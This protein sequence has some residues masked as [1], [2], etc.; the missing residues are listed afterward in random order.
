MGLPLQ[1]FFFRSTDTYLAVK[2]CGFDPSIK[3][4]ETSDLKQIRC[5]YAY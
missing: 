1:V 4:Q 2:L 5:Y 3:L